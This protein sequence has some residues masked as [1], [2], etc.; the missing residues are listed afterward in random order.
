MG[1]GINIKFG[2]KI[3]KYKGTF[4]TGGFKPNF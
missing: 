3:K 4:G 1:G 2:P